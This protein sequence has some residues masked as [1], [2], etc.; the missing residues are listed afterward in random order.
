MAR[1][2]D[3]EW[4]EERKNNYDRSSDVDAAQKSKSGGCLAKN[5][6]IIFFVF[7][8]LLGGAAGTLIGVFGIE[9]MK[10]WVGLGSSEEASEGAG[11]P[12]E[13]EDV[14]APDY[15]FS[16]CPSS[17][18]CCNGLASNCDLKVN[19]VLY[20]TVHNAN[21]DDRTAFS[22]NIFPLE[23]A[24]TAGYRGL[25]LDVCKC[26]NEQDELEVIFCH[27]LCG[28]GTRD[29]VEVFTN[30]NTFLN[31]NSNEMLMIN[32]E[33]SVGDPTPAELWATINEVNEI[34]SKTYDHT[35]GSWPT[36]K[37]MQDNNEQL[38]LFKHGGTSCLNDVSGDCVSKI[39]EFHAFAVET[40]Y[41]FKNVA[42]VENENNSCVENRGSGGTKEFYAINNFVENLIAA[43]SEAGSKTVNEKVFLTNRLAECETTTSLKANFI[44]VDFWHLGDVIEVVQEENKLRGA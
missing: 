28:I 33:L 29:P 36:M 2:R 39:E 37:Q 1:Q 25:M 19:E 4:N 11:D 35:G 5:K 12:A 24:I 23:D 14:P 15:L 21:H 3:E 31:D 32:F 10:S 18:D 9:E 7:L 8:G 27:G 26:P 6:C 38:I 30:I 40:K 20:A 41:Q 16:Q 43:P 42:E 13:N 34:S 22:N 44:A 17:G